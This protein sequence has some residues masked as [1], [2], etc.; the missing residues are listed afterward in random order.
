MKS[1]KGLQGDGGV[2]VKVGETDNSLNNLDVVSI[3]PPPKVSRNRTTW[4]NPKE[5]KMT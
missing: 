5:K 4:R 1:K 3:L 2:G